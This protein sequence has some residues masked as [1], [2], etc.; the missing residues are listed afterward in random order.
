MVN[1]TDLFKP[2][3]LKEKND[4][5][6][7]T[8]CPDCG[9]QGGRTEGFVLFP[10]SNTSYC[11]S[12]HKWFS[13]LETAGLK[14]N[15][16]KCVYKSNGTCDFYEKTLENIKN[17]EESETK[18]EFMSKLITFYLT[19]IAPIVDDNDMYS[20]DLNELY[21]YIYGSYLDN[22]FGD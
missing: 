19:T 7:Q 10:E 15:I 20:V 8:V 14:L 2:E 21:K 17:D 6:F 11:H 22:V 3:E 16:M 18:I 4:G 5:N 13:L 9:L 1:I 12:S